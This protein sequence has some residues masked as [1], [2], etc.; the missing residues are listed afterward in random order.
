MTTLDGFSASQTYAVIVLPNGGP[1][2][3]SFIFQEASTTGWQ[4]ASSIFWQVT[5]AIARAET[6]VRF[7]VSASICG[8]EMPD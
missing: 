6:L 7:E 5:K 4:Q 3:E 1:D 2:L 8:K